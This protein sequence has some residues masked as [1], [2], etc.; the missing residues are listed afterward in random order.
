M[1]QKYDGDI[2]LEARVRVLEN[3]LEEREKALKLAVNGLETRLVLLNELRGDVLTKAE[4]IRAHDNVIFR[5]EKVEAMQGRF[6]G[7]SIALVAMAGAAG[8]VIS[9]LFK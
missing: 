8:A 9:H 3:I 6:V 4:Y 5:L 7:V 2:C 1:N